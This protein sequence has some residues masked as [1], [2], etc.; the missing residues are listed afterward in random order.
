MFSLKLNT[1][2]MCVLE[3]TVPVLYGCF[4]KCYVGVF[5]FFYVVCN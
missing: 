4:S 5:L 3:L 2:L 1:V